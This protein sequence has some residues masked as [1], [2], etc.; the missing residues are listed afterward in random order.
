M[1][2]Y[3]QQPPQGFY[4]EREQAQQGYYQ[5]GQGGAPQGGELM[6]E[7]P[8]QGQQMQYQHDFASQGQQVRRI[9]K[10][11]PRKP[12]PQTPNPKPPI[13]NPTPRIQQ[14]GGYM[15]MVSVQP[16]QQQQQQA[17]QAP[18]MFAPSQPMPQYQPAYEQQQQQLY[19]QP[20]PQMQYSAPIQPTFSAPAAMPAP[21]PPYQGRGKLIKAG[22]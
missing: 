11:R 10:P 21:A 16:Q 22:Q 12:N 1:Q 14:P 5:G 4:E 8:S 7:F 6:R 20:M 18:Q 13:P 15:D 9:P 2:S 19:S 3:Q 17:P